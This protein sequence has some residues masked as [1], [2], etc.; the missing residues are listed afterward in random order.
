MPPPRIQSY[1]N[2]QIL[3]WRGKIIKKELDCCSGGFKGSP[4]PP[5]KKGII[6]VPYSNFPFKFS[7][8]GGQ[9]HLQFA[10]I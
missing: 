5:N 3:N 1:H 7:G 9:K 6:Q 8:G 2:F 10:D 4:P